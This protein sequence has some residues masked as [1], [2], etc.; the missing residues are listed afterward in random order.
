MKSN[1]EVCSVN[2]VHSIDR[3]DAPGVNMRAPG[4]NHVTRGDLSSAISRR[5]GMLPLLGDAHQMSPPDL[6]AV[7]YEVHPPPRDIKII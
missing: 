6:R 3:F 5:C 4:S 7:L 1:S 2:E